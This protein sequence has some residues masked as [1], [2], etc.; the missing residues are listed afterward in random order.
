MHNFIP[1]KKWHWIACE[2]KCG[3]EN[4]SGRHLEVQLPTGQWWDIDGRAVNC[5]AP[6]DRKHRCWIRYGELPFI[7]INKD[8]L[9][10]DAGGGSILVR[11]PNWHGRLQN[12]NFYEEGWP[13]G[14]HR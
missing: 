4:C 2:F 1:L 14:L 3:W 8:G 12:G 9:T 10:C 13:P 5:S 11:Y 6:H 7:T